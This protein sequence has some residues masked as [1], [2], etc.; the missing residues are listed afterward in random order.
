MKHEIDPQRDYY[1]ILG[2]PSDADEQTIKRAY[3]QLARRHHPDAVARRTDQ[4]EPPEQPEDG[5]PAVEDGAPAPAGGSERFHEIQQAY[6]LL[7]D[8]QQREAYD[9]WRRQE[10]LD[11]PP[12]LIMST[13]VSHELLPCLGEYQTLYVLVTI[14]AA[15]G[16]ES[17]RMPLNLCL[18]LDRSTSM[19][20]ARL[21][22]VKEAARY[23]VDQL[24]ENDVLSVISFSDR[25]ETV[26]AGQWPADKAA[27][28]A[29]I[30]RIQAGGG[31]E[32][33]QGLQAGL[34]ELSR[35]RRDD[36][37]N[38]LILLTDG[39]TYGDD[40][41]CLEQAGWAGVQRIQLVTMGIGPDW[42]DDLLDR[43]AGLSGGISLYIDSTAKISRTFQE[44][45][46]TMGDIFAQNLALVV[47]CG[48]G[49]EA[50]EIF[51][52]APQ[53]NP[54]QLD[55]SRVALDSL[56]KQ[57]PQAVLLELLVGGQQPGQIRLLQL[58]LEGSVPAVGDQ[59]VRIQQDVVVT[60]TPD[61]TVASGQIGR[62]PVPPDIVT[63]MGKL[64]I[65]K[66][67]A[68]AMAEV[69]AGQI[70]TA[71][72]RLKT[73]ATRLLSIGE[74]ELAR[75]ALLEAGHLAQTGSLSGEGRKKLR[76]GTRGLTIVP[77]EVRP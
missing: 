44:Q 13:I 49:V 73:M 41:A 45:I 62:P 7:N 47:H 39:Q 4:P 18:V 25:A 31:T 43:M 3:R 11:R 30:S 37:L 35:W 27:A 24:G 2:V 16:I 65:Y 34:E 56:E 14:S 63:A 23:I 20:G 46:H 28:R 48:E 40:Q 72:N 29:A 17:R 36:M 8:P 60:F 66:M 64:T 67:Q 42:N 75:A 6:E 57:Q 1:A 55:D 74:A 10:G 15:E 33:L 5:E 77:K 58:S 76:Y 22:Q 59:M 68:R 52:I 71:V 54:L 19:R 50:R 38:S 69:E 51:R 53:I 26:V 32:L 21:Q 70:D 12:A 61:L 9:H